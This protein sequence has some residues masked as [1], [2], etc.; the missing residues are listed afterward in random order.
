MKPI[1]FAGLKER[2]SNQLA[3]MH[4]VNLLEFLSDF[5]AC[6]CK[7]TLLHIKKLQIN[8]IRKQDF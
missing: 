8:K 3:E 6:I 7:R 5:A 1:T 4:P 2:K